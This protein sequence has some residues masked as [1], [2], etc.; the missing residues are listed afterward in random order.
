MTARAVENV[1][2]L[3]QIVLG[4]SGEG[5]ADAAPGGFRR[6]VAVAFP[7]N[8]GQNG[9]VGVDGVDG[10]VDPE[11]D[12]DPEDDDPE[13]DD[14][15]PDGVDDPDGDEDP[16]G[17]LGSVEVVG[18]GVEDGVGVAGVLEVSGVSGVTMGTVTSSVLS[19]A[20]FTLLP[21]PETWML[22]MGALT[23][24]FWNCM[25]MSPKPPS[26]PWVW[27]WLPSTPKMS[28]PDPLARGPATLAG[29]AGVTGTTGA[30]ATAAA[31]CGLGH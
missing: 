27:L 21:V 23:L 1:I 11:E 8:E 30:A 7:F 17:V 24:T 20:T 16:D 9:V 19:E 2:E 31:G 18:V 10:V 25:P 12:D 15:D 6:L 4:Q 29:T 5:G 26:F 13:D 22:V 3:G 14:E 28:S